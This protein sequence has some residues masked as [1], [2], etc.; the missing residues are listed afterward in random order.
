VPLAVEILTPNRLLVQEEIDELN[1]PGALGYLGILP[2]H[3][4]LLTNLGQGELMYRKGEQRRSLA[5]FCGYMEVNDDKVT[6]LAEIAERAAEIDRARVESARDRALE[7]LR[8]RTD[9]DI[10]FVRAQAALAR[11]LIRLQVAQRG[12]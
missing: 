3:I 10:D 7:R 9:R 6:V 4:A 5:L 2:G 8:N 12:V 11:A 1:V